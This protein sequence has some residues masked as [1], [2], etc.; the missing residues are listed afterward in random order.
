[1]LDCGLRIANPKNPKSKIQTHGP[2]IELLKK[3]FVF[4]SHEFGK[5]LELDFLE[6]R[7]LLGDAALL[8]KRQGQQSDYRITPEVKVELLDPQIS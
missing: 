1:M 8:D 7:G 5:A 4:T 2:V 6:F 3:H